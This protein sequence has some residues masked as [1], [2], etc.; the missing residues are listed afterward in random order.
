MSKWL[1][2]C[3]LVAT[4]AAAQPRFDLLLKGGHVIDPKNNISAVRDVAISNGK[5]AAVAPNIAGTAALKTVDVTGLYVVPGL[6]D[7]H[8][9]VLTMSGLLFEVATFTSHDRAPTDGI[10]PC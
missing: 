8:T 3:V 5:I 6:V 7:I 1:S 4:M 10:F 9:H 2:I